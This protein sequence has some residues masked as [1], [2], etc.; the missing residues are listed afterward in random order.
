MYGDI[1]IGVLK[2]VRYAHR[3][4]SNFCDHIVL[5]DRTVF[6]RILFSCLFDTS[7]WPLVW[8]WYGVAI[9]WVIPNLF[10]IVL[11][12]LLQ[13]WDPHS[14]PQSLLNKAEKIA[15]KQSTKR[16]S[17]RRTVSQTILRDFQPYL[18][19]LVWPRFI[20][21]QRK[22]VHASSSFWVSLSQRR[23]AIVFPNRCVLDRL[24][25]MPTW[26]RHG[27][28]LEDMDALDR[29]VYSWLSFLHGKWSSEVRYLS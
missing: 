10:S 18:V 23:C 21:Q 22:Y 20:Q 7:T 1:S 16:H 17:H 12:S 19:K 8:G 3:A 9:L 2:A 15:A 25:V 26:H 28:D 24:G 14:I 27:S 4:S 29:V 5:D 13:K 11:N 6:S